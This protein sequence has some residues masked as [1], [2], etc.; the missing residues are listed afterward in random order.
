MRYTRTKFLPDSLNS[1]PEEE[2]SKLSTIDE[3]SVL[4]KEREKA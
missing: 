3:E 4:H 1:S 2:E